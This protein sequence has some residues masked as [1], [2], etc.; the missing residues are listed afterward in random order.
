MVRFVNREPELAFLEEQY[1]SDSSSMVII[2]GRRRLGKTSLIRE[3]SRD[4][5]FLY[6][7]ASEE[8]EQ[9]NMRTLKNQIVEFTGDALLAQ[10]NIDNWDILFQTLIRY[11]KN[12]RLVLAIDEFQYLGRTNPA[13]PSIFQ[14]VW[15]MYL[16]NSNVMV[17]LCG[18]LVHMMEAQTL[19][20]SSPLYGRRTGQIKLKQIDFRHYPD[21]FKGLSYKGLIEHY[22]VTGGV[23]KYIALFDGQED[24]FSEIERLV[25]N[26]QSLLF[27]E[28]VFLLRNEVTEI[29]SYFSVIKSI[30]AGNHR[31]S[32]ICA[33]LGVNQTNMPKYL[34]TLIDLDIIGRE[35]PIT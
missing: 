8:A 19:N 17:I 1:K 15:D 14:R 27:E 24:L 29:G 32:K 12:Q 28:P 33:D 25:L 16:Q 13:F 21:F 20:Y 10:A 3:F 5:P 4:K 23:P 30:A 2:Y 7:L 34:K 22:A 26:K 11:I 31:L 6:F 18:S 35:L 9:L